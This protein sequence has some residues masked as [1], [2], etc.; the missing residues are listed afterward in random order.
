MEIVN[1]YHE[2][3]CNSSGTGPGSMLCLEKTFSI[4]LSWE[5][6]VHSV[7]PL[8]WATTV[9]IGNFSMQVSQRDAII[10][11]ILAWKLFIL[12][13][14]WSTSCLEWYLICCSSNRHP[15][16]W[17][18]S[19]SSWSS[20]YSLIIQTTSSF[21]TGLSLSLWSSPHSLTIQTTF[22]FLI[23]LSLSP[24]VISCSFWCLLDSSQPASMASIPLSSIR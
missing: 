16:S 17:L 22:S 20:P 12:A 14:N 1:N 5:H 2:H 13:W 7:I 8:G 18:V 9:K 23:G 21:L 24:W 19:L 10:S 6:L 15:L 11:A 4:C 3:T